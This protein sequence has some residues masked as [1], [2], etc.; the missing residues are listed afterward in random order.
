MRRSLNLLFLLLSL[1]CQRAQRS[2]AGALVDDA[3]VATTL[4]G[5]A[6]RIVSLIPATTELLF[7]LGAG[8]RVVGRTHWCD[9]PA[10]AAQR[11]D[12]GNGM[13][14]NV[15]AV[16]AARPD[17]VLLYR[18][19]VNRGAAERL[20]ALRIPVL[21]LATDRVADLD[22]IIGLLGRALGLANRADSLTVAIRRDLAAATVPRDS[23]AAPR[24]F[25]LVWDRPAMTLGR[26]SFLS[27]LLER[28]GARNAFDDLP[29]SSGQVSIE[30]VA[31]RDPDF[32]L[33]T[34]AGDPAMAER[35]EWRVVRAVRERR[36]L[37]VEGSEFNRPSPRVGSAVR[38]LHAALS[39]LR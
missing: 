24:V 25:I 1:A 3:G 36:F 27:E 37:R 22:R 16:V 5:P 31:A 13:E 18:S 30:A 39:A 6:R 4:A 38:K 10:E 20:R 7:A 9:Y 15:E 17:L 8:E 26:G 32:I 33:A 28:A 12:L 19:G 23:V 34:S 29:S 21:E 14:P 35:P 2:E 11:P